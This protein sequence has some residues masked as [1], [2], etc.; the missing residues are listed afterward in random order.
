MEELKVG[1]II[2]SKQCE[3]SD[4]YKRF[5]QIVKD[6][7]I[8]VQMVNKGDILNLEEDLFF[9]VLWPNNDKLISENVLNNNSMVFK[10]NYKNFSMIFTGDVEEVAE[11]QILEAYKEN[12][13]LFNSN[14][15]KVAHHGSKT[16]SIKEFLEVVRP[17]IALI[18]VGENNKF[19]HPNSEVLE[20]LEELDIKLYRTDEMGEISI[21]V[22]KKGKMKMKK[23]IEQ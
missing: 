9:Y 2:I 6:K 10:M 5:R 17:K 3:D 1:K 7:K 23:Y 11:R 14:I 8:K 21:I 16:S 4:N 12:L 13:N 20:R 18:G 22:D 19:G 15:L